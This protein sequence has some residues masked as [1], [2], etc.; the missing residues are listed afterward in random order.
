M[1]A[2]V[3]ADLGRYHYG[4]GTVIVGLVLLALAS[5][6]MGQVFWALQDTRAALADRLP[7]YTPDGR[8]QFDLRHFRIYD[9][10]VTREAW[11]LG[12]LWLLWVLVVQVARRPVQRVKAVRRLAIAVTGVLA[13]SWGMALWVERLGASV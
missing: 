12:H 6:Y 10:F 8:M 1:G 11:A 13:I 4:L 9:F 2:S 3:K 5:I 7:A